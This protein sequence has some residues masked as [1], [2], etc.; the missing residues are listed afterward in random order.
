VNPDLDMAQN[1]KFQLELF[2]GLERWISK[3]R[4]D[5]SLAS[6]FVCFVDN[7]RITGQQQCRVREMGHAIS[8][9]QSYLGIQDALCKLKLG[10][11]LEGPGL[12][13]VSPC[14]RRRNVGW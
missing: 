12:G 3:H 1:N 11:T 14:V 7:L 4:V 9:K 8:P 6:D 10:M 13:R 2:G 5:G